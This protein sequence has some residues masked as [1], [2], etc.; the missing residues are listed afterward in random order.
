MKK[1]LAILAVM[2]LGLGMISCEADTPLEETE[3]LFE[4]LDESASDDEDVYEGG[5][6]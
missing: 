2:V 3:A 5:R 6:T 1:T 4:N